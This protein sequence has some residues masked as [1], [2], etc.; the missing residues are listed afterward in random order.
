MLIAR[1][2]MPETGAPGFEYDTHASR[3]SA[4]L[5]IMILTARPGFDSNFEIVTGALPVYAIG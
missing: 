5:R 1:K 4:D 2:R 3:A